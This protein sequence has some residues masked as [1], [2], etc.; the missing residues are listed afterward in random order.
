MLFLVDGRSGVT[1]PGR[2]DCRTIATAQTP[3]LAVLVNKV[4]RDDANSAKI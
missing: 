3:D 4:D 2:G 1:Q